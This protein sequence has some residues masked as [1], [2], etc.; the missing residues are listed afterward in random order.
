MWLALDFLAEFSRFFTIFATKFQP[1]LYR[2]SM[3]CQKLPKKFLWI[4]AHDFFGH[5][6]CA[7]QARASLFVRYVGIY[8]DM[9]G[10]SPGAFHRDTGVGI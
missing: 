4:S 10:F 3:A 5:F 8:I 1:L 2:V 6:K 7:V 9:Q